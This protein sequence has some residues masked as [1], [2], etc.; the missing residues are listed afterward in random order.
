VGDIYDGIRFPRETDRESTR[1]Y[2][3]LNMAQ[4]AD[5]RAAIEGKA[6]RL[7]TLVDR[8]VMRT[9]RSMADAVMVGGGTI[10]A[11]RLSLGLDVEDARP[12]PRA[13]ILTNSGD[14]P[15]E[16]N[17]VRDHRQDLLVLLPDGTDKGAEKR[18][19]RLAET[20]RVPV[21][22][23]GAIDVG[24]ALEVM[25]SE[26]GVHVLL[27]E[28]GPTLNRALVSADLADELFIT[29]APMLV[30]TGSPEDA[31]SSLHKPLRLISSHA[32]GDEVFLRY[33]TEK[34]G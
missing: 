28:G 12:I 3:I 34:R 19:G 2:V 16:T 6:S 29:M 4:S 5:G 24:R 15:L 14:L 23:A 33:A 17:L 26:Y 9:L 32:L 25:K 18:L 30:G 27:C 21:T 10:R 22:E 7:G 20:R 31:R 8:G 11:E 1:P 13:V